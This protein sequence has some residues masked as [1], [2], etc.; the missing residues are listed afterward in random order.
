MKFKNFDEVLEKFNF[1]D[2][3][4]RSFSFYNNINNTHQVKRYKIRDLRKRMKQYI[5]IY[6]YFS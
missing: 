6:K 3:K 4:S 5:H 2:Q 1:H